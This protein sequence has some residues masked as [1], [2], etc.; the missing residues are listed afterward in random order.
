[1]KNERVKVYGYDVQSGPFGHA[2]YTESDCPADED[3]TVG[4]AVSPC[5]IIFDDGVTIENVRKDSSGAIDGW[6]IFGVDYI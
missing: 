1:M 2:Y 4:V 3:L 6:D 5:W